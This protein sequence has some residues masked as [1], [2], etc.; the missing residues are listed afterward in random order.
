MMV[1]AL[2]TN[3]GD[4]TFGT[5]KSSYLQNNMAVAQRVQTRLYCY[6]N[7]CFFDTTLGV[8]WLNLLGGKNVVALNLAISGMI[9]NTEE[10]IG[11]NQLTTRLDPDTRG[12][13]VQYNV[14]TVYSTLSGSFQ[15]QLVQ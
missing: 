11:I 12:F 7:N 5:G 4:W 8:D 3:T 6:L 9:L 13:S 1:R 10:I 2:D 14:Q 15:F